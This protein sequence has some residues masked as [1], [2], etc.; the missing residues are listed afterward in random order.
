MR[1]FSLSQL[2]VESCTSIYNESSAVGAEKQPTVF[3]L[4]KI[5]V[6]AGF[7]LLMQSLSLIVGR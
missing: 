3:L 6:E 5:K 7:L 1:S 2:V 4:T